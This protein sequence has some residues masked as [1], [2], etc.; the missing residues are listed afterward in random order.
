MADEL[1]TYTVVIPMAGHLIVTVQAKDEAEAK[2]KAFDEA[3]LNHLEDW[4]AL[5][6]FNQGNVCHCPS[7]W[8]VEIIEE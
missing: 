6:K 8:E 2:D 4:E 3:D 7:P 1:K 5:E